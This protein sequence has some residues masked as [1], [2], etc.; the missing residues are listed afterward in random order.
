MITLY[1]E[2]KNPV[3]EPILINNYS[4]KN[5]TEEGWDR[6]LK[7]QCTKISYLNP[8]THLRYIDLNNSNKIV[9]L[10]NLKKN[11]SKMTDLKSRNKKGFGKI[12]LSNICTFDTL[13]SIFMV[14]YF[15]SKKYS[16]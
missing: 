13:S 6:K 5:T 16:E 15:D 7:K 4:E 1:S 14:S 9:S 12:A 2:N 3:N 11:G 10:P 8:N